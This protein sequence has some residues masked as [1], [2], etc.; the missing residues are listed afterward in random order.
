MADALFLGGIAA[1]T[2]LVIGISSSPPT[3]LTAAASGVLL[4]AALQLARSR[5]DHGATVATVAGAV[6]GIVLASM[7]A[8]LRADGA[9][10]PRRYADFV[11]STGFF[12]DT[13]VIDVG[14][15]ALAAIGVVVLVACLVSRWRDTIDASARRSVLGAGALVIGCALVH[16]WFL[17]F[18]SDS[19]QDETTTGLHTFFGGYVLLGLAVVG[20]VTVRGRR[21]LIWVATA[22]S[23]IALATDGAVT[24]GA[25]LTALTAILVVGGA[26]GTTVVLRGTQAPERIRGVPI[27]VAVLAV[28]AATQFI[29]DGF[30]EGVPVLVGSFGVP[31]VVAMAITAAVIAGRP[32]PATVV[33][34][35]ALLTLTRLTTGG[36]F[37]WTAY[38]PL[39]D[40]IGFD[41]IT[42]DPESTSQ[43]VVALIALATCLVAAVVLARRRDTAPSVA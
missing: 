18:I 32:D 37:G 38:T 4:G 39:T 35:L 30:W 36:D 8:R 9:E 10:R 5:S 27:A 24:T 23:T 21:G 43:T 1:I 40:G 15:V 7:L 31:V 41:G 33:G 22:A 29:T 20:A 16:W 19:L 2:L 14:A 13:T 42:G 11:P 34:A 6:L 17:R 3:L 25:A 26:L 28:F 12:A